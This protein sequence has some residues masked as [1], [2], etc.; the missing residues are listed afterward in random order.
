MIT[1]PRS[2][3]N[4]GLRVVRKRSDGFHDIDT[5]FYPVCLCDALEF[6]VPQG[7][8]SD[9]ALTM[10]GIDINTRPEKNMVIRAVK[11]LREKYP[12]PFLKIHLHKAIPSG[13][14]LGGGSSDAASM[15]IALNK[16]FRLSVAEESLRKLAL[17]LGSDCPFFINPVPSIAGGRGEIIK[18]A[19]ILPDGYRIILVNPGI[20]IST[21]DA[22]IN[23]HP[24]TEGEKIE[25]MIMTNIREW[26]KL[27]KNDFEDYVFRIYPLIHEIKKSLYRSGAVY[28]SMS[29]SGSTVYGIFEGK[30]Q[31]SKKIREYVLWEGNL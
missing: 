17:E 10:T 18:P 6:V 29:G 25:N 19:G 1:F 9:D 12:F 22:Y 21:R 11:L 30:P 16:C 5:L 31:I 4:I 3:I 26:K 24:S 13:A 27:I 15:L 20:I 23:T 14:G 28:A 7:N 8:P 2:K